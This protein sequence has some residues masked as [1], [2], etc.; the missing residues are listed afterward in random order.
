[1]TQLQKRS[2]SF[3]GT[4]QR[5]IGSR[6]GFDT[7]RT[8]TLDY[9]AWESKVS[10]GRLQGGEPIAQ[11]SDNDK[12]VP[13]ASGGSNGTNKLVGF[14]RND[15]PVVTGAGDIVAAMLDRGRIIVKYLPST[16]SVTAT[17]TGFFQLIDPAHT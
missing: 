5:W 16:V 4:D 3:G 9:A 11:R 2:E 12:W 10:N 17:Q 1:M 8:V 15:H 14:L 7:A 6:E 13:Y